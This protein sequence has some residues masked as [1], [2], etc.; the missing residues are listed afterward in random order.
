MTDTPKPTYSDP[1]NVKM[2]FAPG[3]I[4]LSVVG[5][6]AVFTFTTPLPPDPQKLFDGAPGPVAYGVVSR[7]AILKDALPS[8]QELIGRVAQGQSVATS[9]HATKH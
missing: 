6:F 2:D 7:V 8:L 5:P 4:S 1:H 9:D 3:P